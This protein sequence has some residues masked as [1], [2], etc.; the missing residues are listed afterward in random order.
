M[1][2]WR[3]PIASDWKDASG[4]DHHYILDAITDFTLAFSLNKLWGG[5][6]GNC[7]RVR[8]ISDN[9]EQN[10]GF[11]SNN[12]LDVASLLSFCGG[13]TA[14][15]VT[16]FNQSRNNTISAT[17]SDGA[18]QAIIVQSGSYLGYLKGGADVFYSLT[19]PNGITNSLTS[20]SVCAKSTITNNNINGGN[21]FFASMGNFAASSRVELGASA[22]GNN[23]LIGERRLDS[24]AEQT[25]TTNTNDFLNKSASI[26][27]DFNFSSATASIYSD[28]VLNVTANPYQTAGSTAATNS[29]E[30][31]IM[32]FSTID[33]SF[34]GKAYEILFL[35]RSMTPTERRLV[36]EHHNEDF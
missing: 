5:Y 33:E 8:R 27:A 34:Y 23:Y 15:V 6:E 17:Q 32:G 14:T 12:N 9:A 20:C 10:I 4:W 16:W 11:D 36:T 7:L 26:I 30:V 31:S 21:L 29:Q 25:L 22:D 28:N 2:I 1:G 19:S 3:F 35:R 18:S 13:S 24:D